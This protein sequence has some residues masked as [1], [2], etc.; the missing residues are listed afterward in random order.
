MIDIT[1]TAYEVT[2]YVE[3]LNLS[4]EVFYGGPLSLKVWEQRKYQRHNQ[5][6]GM[7][8]FLQGYKG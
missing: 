8:K 5:S 3:V 2:L 6:R 1:D 7:T 4:K